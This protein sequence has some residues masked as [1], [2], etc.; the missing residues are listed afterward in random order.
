M[1][2]AG[3]S[4]KCS[5]SSPAVPTMDSPVRLEFVVRPPLGAGP[6]PGS[7]RPNGHCS[8]RH[9]HHVSVGE[10]QRRVALQRRV[11]A[12]L[13]VGGLKVGKCPFKI[14]GMPEQPRNVASILDAARELGIRDAQ[15]KWSSDVARDACDHERFVTVSH[16]LRLCCAYGAV[17]ANRTFLLVC[18]LCEIAYM[19]LYSF[20]PTVV[21]H[22]HD[23]VVEL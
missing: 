19:R 17:P 8:A 13:V 21:T 12:Y 18:L 15:G 2:F 22:C 5:T 23:R 6:S 7:G 4:R 10:G 9:G 20:G 1:R 16:C 3:S 11:A 14:T